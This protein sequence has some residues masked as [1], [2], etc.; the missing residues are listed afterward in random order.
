MF[1]FRFRCKI[2]LR[3][4]LDIPIG[5]MGLFFNFI[6]TMISKVPS[7]N[8]KASD[9]LDRT[10]SNQSYNTTLKN[11]HSEIHRILSEAVTLDERS[12][13]ADDQSERDS[14]LQHCVR[15]SVT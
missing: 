3:R 10:P 4:V 5:F 12:K 13:A 14:K 2:E 11:Y 1:G 15:C 9:S 6:F 7:I 8:F